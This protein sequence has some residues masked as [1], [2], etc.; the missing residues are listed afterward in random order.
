MLIKKVSDRLNFLVKYVTFV[1]LVMMTFIIV[2]QV[3]FRKVLSSSLSWSE[4]SAR[5]LF[6]W[7]IMLGVSIGVKEGFHVAVTIF[8][9]KLP[10]TSRIVSNIIFSMLLGVMAMVMII[11]GYDLANIVAVQLSPAVRLSMYWVYLSVPVS[12]VLIMI[13][14][15]ENIERNVRNLFNSEKG[16]I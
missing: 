2:L 13:H 15:L 5:Y 3:F 12:G 9:N 1:Q 10:K 8:I 11:Y 7:I 4:E 6:I 14:L 16:V